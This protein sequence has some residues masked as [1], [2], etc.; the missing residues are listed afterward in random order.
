[1]LDF[2]QPCDASK[3]F[4]LINIGAVRVVSQH[5]PRAV[6]TVYVSVLKDLHYSFSHL[7]STVSSST[8]S[9]ITDL[10]KGYS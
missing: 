1:M 9:E 8:V 3:V 2:A 7:E 6:K 10:N 5:S 4:V